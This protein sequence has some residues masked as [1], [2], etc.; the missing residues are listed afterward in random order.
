MNARGF[1]KKFKIMEEMK[2]PLIL[3]KIATILLP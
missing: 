1:L 2:N 3:R